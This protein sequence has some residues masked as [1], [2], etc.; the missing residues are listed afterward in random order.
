V[1]K[2][3]ELGETQRSRS[4]TPHVWSQSRT[5]GHR[6]SRIHPFLS[7]ARLVLL[8]PKYSIDRF[9]RFYKLENSQPSVSNAPR[10]PIA[11]GQGL[12]RRRP[13]RRCAWLSAA[14]ALRRRP[15][16]KGRQNVRAS[17]ELQAPAETNL[18]LSDPSDSPSVP[19]GSSKR[20]CPSQDS[21][22]GTGRGEDL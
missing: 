3:H 20:R 18:L 1:R 2:T 14:S 9:D 17:R 5:R 7:A 22:L 8:S 12:P 19:L 4:A 6:P 15:R 11:A 21:A 16:Q 10:L 13:V